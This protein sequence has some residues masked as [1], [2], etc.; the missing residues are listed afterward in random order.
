MGALISGY[1]FVIVSVLSSSLTEYVQIEGNMKINMPLYIS[2]CTTA[3]SVGGLI[4][5]LFYPIFLSKVG[6]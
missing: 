5:S 3:L 2:I 6:G 1:L 4:G